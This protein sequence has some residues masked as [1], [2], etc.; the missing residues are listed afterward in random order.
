MLTYVIRRLALAIPTLLGAATLTFVLL[1]LVPGD[2]ARILAGPSATAPDIEQ[3]RHQLGLDRPIWEQ[4]FGFLGGLLNGDL[5]TSFR[6]GQS[7][8]EQIFQ[9]APHT[10][11]LTVLSLTLA[12]VVGCVLGIVAA[13]RRGTVVDSAVSVVSVAGVSMPP[14]WIGL[15]LIILFSVNLGWLP[16]AGATTWQSRVLP[17]FTLALFPIGYISRQTR[18]AMVETLEMDYIRSARAKGLGRWAVVVRHAFRNAALPI[19]TIIGLQFGALLGG[20]VLTETIFA[21]PGMGRL[22]VQSIS[23]RDYTT[24]QGTIFVLG[25]ALIVVNIVVDLIYA[26]LDPRI[27]YD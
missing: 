1:R 11:E 6:T 14:Y 9:R 2:P 17:V 26:Y 16:V 4:Y 21:W 5:G 8:S 22:L 15:L 3:L 19:V 10:L 20:A 27:R 23:V 18:A 13:I 12:T 7:V 24:I 25:V